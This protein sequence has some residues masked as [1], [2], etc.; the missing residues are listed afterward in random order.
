ML[1]KTTKFG[2]AHATIR[3]VRPQ[4]AWALRAWQIVLVVVCCGLGSAITSPARAWTVDANGNVT[5]DVSFRVPPSADDITLIT[6]EFNRA[7]RVL[8]DAT[9]GQVKIHTVNFNDSSGA[10]S[11]A[12]FWLVGQDGRSNA[13]EA[14]TLFRPAWYASI[15]AHELGHRILGLLDEYPED[16]INGGCSQGPSFD[17]SVR[18]DDVWN[19]L[20]Q[21]AAGQVCRD[22]AGRSLSDLNAKDFPDIACRDDA[23]CGMLCTSAT[24]PRDGKGN[25]LAFTCPN[26]SLESELAVALNYDQTRGTGEAC[27]APRAGSILTLNAELRRDQWSS[28]PMGGTPSRDCGNNTIDPGEQCDGGQLGGATCN[29]LGLTSGMLR[30]ASNCAFDTSLCAT[31]ATCGNGALEASEKCDGA[32]L[33]SDVSCA[34]FGFNGTNSSHVRENLSCN[35]NCTINASQC[36]GTTVEPDTTSFDSLSKTTHSGTMV[37]ALDSLGKLVGPAALGEGQSRHE[38]WVFIEHGPLLTPSTPSPGLVPNQDTWVLHFFGK[39]K[40]YATGTGDEPRV[41]KTVQLHFTGKTLDLVDGHA[42]T[43][44]ISL[45]L[46]GDGTG[47]FK[48]EDGVV[49]PP[50]TLALRLNGITQESAFTATGFVYFTRFTKAQVSAGE[51]GT[52]GELQLATCP[53]PDWCARVW[54]STTGRYEGTAATGRTDPSKLLDDWRLMRQHFIDLSGKAENPEGFQ[55]ALPSTGFP[56]PAEPT[57]ADC[58]GPI[59]FNNA[60]G[61]SDQVMMVLDRSG[62]MSETTRIPDANNDG[63]TRLEYVKAAAKAFVELSN[64]KPLDVGLISFSGPTPETPD[65]APKVEQTLARVDDAVPAT[66][67][68]VSPSTFQTKIDAIQ[69]NGNTY[70]ADALSTARAQLAASGAPAGAKKTVFLL[71][72][73]ENN[74]PGD[75]A[76]EV[77]KLKAD[78]VTLY[79]VPF[80]GAADGSLLTRLANQGGGDALSVSEGDEAPTTFLE[81]F[82]RRRGEALS[83]PRTASAVAVYHACGRGEFPC[84]SGTPVLTQDAC[85][86]V[87]E[88]EPAPTVPVKQSF[89][90]DVEAGAAQLNVLLSSRD[91]GT[92]QPSFRLLDPRDNLVLDETSPS[93]RSGSLYRLMTVAAPRVGAWLLEITGRSLTPDESAGVQHSFLAA[94]IENGSPRCTL[95]ANQTNVVDGVPVTFTARASYQGAELYDASFSGVVERPDGTRF[96]LNFARAS[97]IETGHSAVFP[98]SANIGRG[99]YRAIVDCKVNDNARFYPGE[100]FGPNNPTPGPAQPDISVT[101]FSR[102]ATTI[103][104]ADSTRQPPLPPGNDADGDGILNANEPAGDT[105]GD[106]LPDAR[107]DDADN[108]DVPD[109]VDPDPTNPDVPRPRTCQKKPSSVACCAT[110]AACSGARSI[111]VYA[112]GSLSINDRVTLTTSGAPAGAFNGGT[113]QTHLGVDSAIGSLV[114]N[115]DVFAA[116]RAHIN[117]D[118]TTSGVLTQQ[119][120]V[121]IAG[122]LTQRAALTFPNLEA[123]TVAFP[124]A[125]QG[126]RSLEPGQSLTLAPG[127]YGNVSIKSRSTLLLST[128]T[129]YLES[130]NVEPQATVRLASTGGPLFLYVKEAFTFKG[131]LLDSQGRND[132][133][134]VGYFG[135][136]DT[137]IESAFA[138]TIVAPKATLWLKTTTVPHR[139]SF[140]A[141]NIDIAANA[142]VEHFPFP[143]AWALGTQAIRGAEWRATQEVAPAGGYTCGV[144]QHGRGFGAPLAVALSALWIARRRR[145]R[146]AA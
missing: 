144:S 22:P 68:S 50:L 52:S 11:K 15:I 91:K 118:L 127:S 138:G 61:A 49:A 75:P 64:K 135:T 94:H 116:E 132:T 108:D 43:D 44:P 106:G 65:E 142:K 146:R 9:D 32:L 88:Q 121:V 112:A 5:L 140:F 119:N 39:G 42:P 19:T 20:M 107:D 86:C 51:P 72:D 24:C 80:S 124:T 30:C 84:G 133:L 69:A 97:D 40:E 141:K 82:A 3:S 145:N 137:F 45:T 73:G 95:H 1:S 123:F 17:K 143:F 2:N 10:V 131:T 59:S 34:T 77:A 63:K 129:Y 134:L 111:P 26:P 89:I 67:P 74:G 18:L 4:R 13:N 37:I 12:D 36:A 120:N 136:A 47:S 7:Q 27:P 55:I 25:P 71:T 16:W 56:E 41:L 70:I 83:L 78:G 58:G 113:G 126:D 102:T 99:I 35:P 122:T 60:V 130:L 54:N 110:L 53:Q 115:G 48:E 87:S 76:D 6:K 85:I 109:S 62:S 46:G 98:A 81:L 8:C 104:F 14:I 114:S 100:T 93:V 28:H 117:G 31:P 23:D 92:W 96:I 66:P 101:A 29:S 57:V 90:L 103:F 38:L 79:T 128:G 21:Q 125:D 139:G 105:D 33:P